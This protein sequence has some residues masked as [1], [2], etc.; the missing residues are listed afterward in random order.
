M[1]VLFFNQLIC[2]ALLSTFG[3]VVEK[4][5]EEYYDKLTKKEKEMQHTLKER[6]ALFNMAFQQDMQLY[7]ESGIIPNLRGEY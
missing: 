2:E 4:L 5:E 1:R 7:K 3:N 6:Q